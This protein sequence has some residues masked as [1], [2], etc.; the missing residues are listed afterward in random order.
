MKN[1]DFLEIVIQVFPLVGTQNPERKANERPQV[2]DAVVSAVVF[3][4]LMNLRV[5][6]VAAGDAV[7][8]VGGL[9]LFIFKTS[10]FEPLLF[11]TG[12]Q[13]AAAVAAAVVVGAVGGHVDEVFFSDD[14]LDDK[15]QV[16]RNR[17]AVALA[18]DLTGILYR[19]LD[20]QVFVPVGIDLEL[21]LPDPFGVILVDVFDDNVVLDVEFF[22]SCQD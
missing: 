17:I 4:Q 2:D 3:A 19:E 6:V 5:A 7:V 22:Q 12:L 14:A 18:D 16:F 20:F 21:A 1:S 15:A 13:E 10:V 8:G 9:N 11:I